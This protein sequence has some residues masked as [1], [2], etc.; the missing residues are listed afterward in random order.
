MAVERLGR[1]HFVSHFVCYYHQQNPATI[2]ACSSP[3][4]T[5]AIE[6][7]IRGISMENFSIG[8][9]SSLSNLIGFLSVFVCVQ[10]NA[11]SV[12]NIVID[13]DSTIADSPTTLLGINHV[14]LS[15]KNL[16]ET[17]AFY[18]QATGYELLSRET[19]SNN[20]A[21]DKL[22]GI[23]DVEYEMAVL[24]GPNMLFELI[25]F[26]HNANKPVSKMPV[27]GPGM[28]HTCFRRG[29]PRSH[30]GPNCWQCRSQQSG[31]YLWSRWVRCRS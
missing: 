3:T 8:R 23:D 1:V 20:P 2:R 13:P 21:A 9:S 29:S 17:L 10:L 11:A 27:F 14:G 18:E 16:D 28:T 31:G 26:K 4:I 5:Q 24:A 15:V 22:F 25:E 7:R 30:R 19:V 12:E 6:V